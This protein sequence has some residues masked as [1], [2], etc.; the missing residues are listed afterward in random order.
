MKT[1]IRCVAL[2]LLLSLCVSGFAFADHRTD[3]RQ[4]GYLGELIPW[5]TMSAGM[6]VVE[7]E[8]A[9]RPYEEITGQEMWGP[10]EEAAF[11][12]LP[13]G[14][15]KT[16]GGSSTA[17]HR[18]RQA[19]SRFSFDDRH[20]RAD[21]PVRVSRRGRRPHVPPTLVF[22]ELRQLQFPNRISRGCT[23]YQ[24]LAGDR[25]VR[26]EGTDDRRQ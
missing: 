25:A 19:G 2:I 13:V 1:V 12:I 24:H 16:K 20:R 23:T 7:L 26:G 22:S 15:G 4:P 17:D 14:P 3:D 21:R 18:T 8:L 10:V 6:R 5:P 9:N 11:G